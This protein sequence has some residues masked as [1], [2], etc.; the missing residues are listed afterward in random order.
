MFWIII[1][2]VIV[3]FTSTYAFEQYTTGQKF[4][5]INFFMFWNIKSPMLT[6]A[7]FIYQYWAY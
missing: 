4:G 5:I 1:C 2:W 3:S 6:K 7:A